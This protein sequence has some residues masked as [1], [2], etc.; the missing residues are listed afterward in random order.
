MENKLLSNL[1]T[2]SLASVVIIP[3][4][5]NTSGPNEPYLFYSELTCFL[6]SSCLVYNAGNR[7]K[8]PAPSIW[9]IILGL[10]IFLSKTLYPDKAVLGSLYIFWAAYIFWIGFHLSEHNRATLLSAIIVSSVCVGIQGWIQYWGLEINGYTIQ[11]ASQYSGMLGPFGQRNLFCDWIALGLACATYRYRKEFITQAIIVIFL[12]ACLAFSNSRMGWIYNLVL[13]VQCLSLRNYRAI[14]YLSSF[15]LFWFH[16]TRT[17]FGGIDGNFISQISAE[18]YR[19][20]IWETSLQLWSLSPTTGI[21][22]GVSPFGFFTLG[23]GYGIVNNAHNLFLHY[24]TESGLIGEAL[25]IAA[26]GTAVYRIVKKI[27]REYS[28]TFAVC[29]IIG[30]HSQVEFP[31]FYS[32]FLLIFCLCLGVMYAKTSD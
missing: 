16:N 9:L 2:I 22:W 6:L 19:G 31:L 21:G 11:Y 1:E 23:T 5:I 28:W 26:L 14:F 29:C 15:F 12:E 25:L 10:Y 30:V 7:I 3:P 27:R 8:L 13:L 24:L 17:Y 4:L 20:Y 32:P 18:P